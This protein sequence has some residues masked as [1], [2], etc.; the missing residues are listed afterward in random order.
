[1]SLCG[2]RLTTV[3]VPPQMEGVL[4]ELEAIFFRTS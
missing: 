2:A 3:V 1:M 4:L